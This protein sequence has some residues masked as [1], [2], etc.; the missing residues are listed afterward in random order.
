VNVTRYTNGAATVILSG[1]LEA[2]ARAALV[3][4]TNGA[5]HVMEAAAEEVRA[6]AEEVWY[7]QVDRETG[8]SG[9]LAVV[10]TVDEARGEVRVTVGSTDPRKDKRGRPAVA[11]IHRP[12]ALSTVAVQITDGEYNRLKSKGG[13][14]AATVFHA[15]FD[16]PHAGVKAGLYYRKKGNPDA[17]D[18]KVLLQELIR[19]PM[20]AKIK[21][22]L[23]DLGR[24]VAARGTHGR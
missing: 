7:R 9:A 14:A 23:P 15:R 6:A 13:T 8:Q 18:G 12:R 4:A 3:Q 1:D 10:T 19:K 2:F 20:R 22:I 24:A 11:F 16:D 21:V 5:I 17:S